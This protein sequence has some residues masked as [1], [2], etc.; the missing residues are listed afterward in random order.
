MHSGETKLKIRQVGTPLPHRLC[1]NVCTL[2]RIRLLSKFWKDDV[3]LVVICRKTTLIL[4]ILSDHFERF[5]SLGATYRRIGALLP[6]TG[7]GMAEGL[8]L[9]NLS[10][11]PSAIDFFLSATDFFLTLFS[12]PNLFML[13]LSMTVQIAE[14]VAA[15]HLWGL[16]LV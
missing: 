4:S 2:C 15:S 14:W 16:I 12:F 5:R 3:A 7:P 13:I 8:R 9:S 6:V 10:S 11:F 1:R